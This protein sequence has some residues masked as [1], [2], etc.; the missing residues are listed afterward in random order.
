MDNFYD[1]AD[2]NGKR[3][4]ISSIYPEKLVFDGEAYRT[5]RLNE[6]VRLIYKLGEG[7]S[8]KENR[9]N[10]GKTRVSGWVVPAR[11]ELTSKV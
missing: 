4:I 3:Q 1:E 2:V 9:K 6:A 7:F 5:K 8:E 10:E 11:I